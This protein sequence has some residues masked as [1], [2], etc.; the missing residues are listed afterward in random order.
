MA[1]TTKPKYNFTPQK[2]IRAHELA[3]IVKCLVLGKKESE[4]F[5]NKDIMR[6]FTKKKEK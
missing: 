5:K 3:E 2:N 4:L 6:H 1:E